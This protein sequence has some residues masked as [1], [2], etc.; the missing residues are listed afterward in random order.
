MSKFK[1]IL[2]GVVRGSLLGLMISFT[3]FVIIPA[4]R[5]ITPRE[6]SPEVKEYVK[7][8]IRYCHLYGKKF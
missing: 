7:Q 8:F 1:E 4:C 3:A 5:S 2:G 6:V